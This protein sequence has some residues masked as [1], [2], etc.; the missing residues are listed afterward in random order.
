[1]YRKSFVCCHS[2]YWRL[3]SGMLLSFQFTE[4]FTSQYDFM[5]LELGTFY[6]TLYN[7]LGAFAKLRIV[8]VSF[9]MC[10]CLSAW[11]NS[12]PMGRI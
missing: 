11:N 5:Y 3:V 9:I 4:L 10:V 6:Y 8:S 1:M 7:F 12:P 2:P